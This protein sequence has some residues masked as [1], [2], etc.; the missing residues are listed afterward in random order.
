MRG[1]ASALLIPL[2]LLLAC[3]PEAGESDHDP[4]PIVRERPSEALR[5]VTST[6]A[7]LLGIEA[8][9][10][11]V[12]KGKDA[13]LIVWSGPPFAATSRPLV[14]LIGGQVVVDRRN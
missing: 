13:D 8:R 1:V 10:G 12:E 2:L 9:V 5:A 4:R 11:T 7:R 14:V 6:P 3:T